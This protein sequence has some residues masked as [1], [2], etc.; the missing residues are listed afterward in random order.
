M[1]STAASCLSLDVNSSNTTR[2]LLHLFH[3]FGGKVQVSLQVVAGEQQPQHT[4]PHDCPQTHWVE[5]WAGKPEE[6]YTHGLK[7]WGGCNTASTPVTQQCLAVR[8]HYPGTEW[9]DQICVVQSIWNKASDICFMA[10]I[11]L[12]L[13]LKSQ[14]K[15]DDKK[16]SKK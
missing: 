1:F 4:Q 9:V 11:G 2:L 8:G 3:P 13:M 5:G 15:S 14:D 6:Q 12:I 10:D 7:H 16:K